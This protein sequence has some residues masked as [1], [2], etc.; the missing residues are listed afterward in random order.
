MISSQGC[1]QYISPWLKEPSLNECDMRAPEVS[2][3]NLRMKVDLG[4]ESRT[5][6]HGTITESLG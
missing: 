1:Q 3:Q 5:R 2:S 6:D 4:T